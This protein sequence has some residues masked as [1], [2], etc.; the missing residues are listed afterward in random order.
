MPADLF[1][2][3]VSLAALNTFGLPARAAGF[4]AIESLARLSALI[5][6][7]EWRGGG[8]SCSAVVAI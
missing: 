6:S 1:Q 5:A 8:A 7:P 2:R 3:D 4:A